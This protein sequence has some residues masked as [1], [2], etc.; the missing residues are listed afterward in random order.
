MLYVLALKKNTTM[1]ILAPQLKEVE[2][3]MYKL[4]ATGICCCCREFALCIYSGIKLPLD[5]KKRLLSR[6]YGSEIS[7][8]ERSRL[9]NY[10]NMY[11][12]RL[13]TVAELIVD[14]GM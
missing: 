4:A 5:I 11:S 1:K 7:K 12:I 2:N 13:Q 6:M 10:L 8:S 14:V 9:D 3:Y